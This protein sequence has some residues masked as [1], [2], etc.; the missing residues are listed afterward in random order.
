MNWIDY[1]QR[2][3]INHLPWETYTPEKN[4]VKVFSHIDIRN[5]KTAI[6]IGCGLGTNSL[7]LDS[8]GIKVDGIDISDIAICAAKNRTNK[9]SK[10]NF[11]TMN[12]LEDNTLKENY[13]DFV[14]DR[15]CIHGMI[16]E[17]I[18]KF[19]SKVSKIISNNGLWMS[20]IGSCEGP[21][22]YN[23]PPRRTCS[24][25]ISLI[26]PYMKVINVSLDSMTISNNIEVNVWILLTKKRNYE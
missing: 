3:D 21:E 6:D 7:W 5:I 1:W 9:N 17:D 18:R 14:F 24:E 15:G 19:A 11:E 12:F 10:I 2:N 26:E 8:L 25:M 23:G 22:V 13:Y 4:L 20:I 16:D